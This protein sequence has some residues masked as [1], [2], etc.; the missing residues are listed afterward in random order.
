[1]AT[2]LYCRDC[3][4]FR[5]SEPNS[6]VYD[7]GPPAHQLE[8][9]IAPQNFKDTYSMSANSV[10]SQPKVINQYNNCGWYSAIPPIPPVP[11]GQELYQAFEIVC[12]N[13]DGLTTEYTLVNEPYYAIPLIFINGLLQRLSVDYTLTGQTIIFGFAVAE[14]SNIQAFYSYLV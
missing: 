6:I 12:G 7:F 3:I 10:I 14:G 13:T 11:P 5:I 8:Q 9:C 4:F 2:N 1:M